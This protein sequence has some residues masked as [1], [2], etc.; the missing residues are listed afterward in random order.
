MR[1]A[2]VHDDLVQYGGAERVLSAICEAFPDAP[3]YTS[4][5]DKS[6]KLLAKVFQGK[7]IKV[8]FMQK[9]PGWRKLYRALLPLYP[10]AFEQFDFSGFDLVISQ[11]T[12]FAKGILTKPET[13]HLCY[14]HTP[15]R[16]LWSYSGE[17]GLKLSGPIL[18]FLKFYD[19]ISARRV[20]CFLAGSK[21][22]QN[23]IKQ[24]YDMDSRVLYP[25]IDLS[26][27]EN[28]LPFEGGYLLCIARL[29]KY[30][31]VD[32]AVKL[33]NK[34]GIPLKVVGKGPEQACLMK[35][36][37]SQ[38]EF[39]SDTSDEIVSQLLLGCKALIVPG[40][41]D[42]GLTPL[43]AAAAGKPVLAFARGGAIESVIE[44]QTGYFF[45]EQ[46]IDAMIGALK[47]LDEHGYNR[48]KCL[49]SA[50][51]FSKERF[52]AELKGIINGL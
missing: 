23:R 45:E 26:R 44:G 34:T 8:S 42:F 19:K 52:M 17:K 16:F 3:I 21:N 15:P 48:V 49:A 27:F 33:S 46:T 29:N 9:I 25:F 24:I 36:A 51:R 43:E 1:V 31:R 13:I 22:A 11:T 47:K 4:L 40:E 41:E 35:I 38:V 50:R 32:L 18:K 39:I 6:N 7:T 2:I 20:D 28:Y 30:K 5:Y 12:R 37:G 10:I 14:C